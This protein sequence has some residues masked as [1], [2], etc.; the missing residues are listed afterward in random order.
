MKKKYILLLLVSFSFGYE[1]TWSTTRFEYWWNSKINKSLFREPVSFIPYKIKLGYYNYGGMK[2][3]DNFPNNSDTLLSSP[4]TSNNNKNFDFIN[5]QK[6]RKGIALE[7]DFLS[8]NFFKKFQ[9]IVDVTIGIGYKLRK[10]SSKLLIP[11]DENNLDENW[12]DDNR[13]FFFNPTVHNLNINTNFI[14]Q[15]SNIFYSYYNFSYG[16]IQA[17][18]FEDYN[19]E[20]SIL[21]EG[22]SRGHAI[23]FNFVS[24]SKTKTYDFH[25]GL[26]LRFDELIINEISDLSAHIE[27]VEIREIGVNLNIGIGYGGKNTIGNTAYSQMINGEYIEA[28][29][30]FTFFKNEYPNH[31]KHKL[32]NKMIDFCNNKIAYQM[33]FKGNEEYNKEKINEALSWYKKAI[34]KSDNNDQ[35]KSEIESRKF[36][37]AD[38]LLKNLNNYIDTHSFDQTLNYL[39]YI[40]SISNRAEYKA[41]SKKIDLLNKKADFLLEKKNYKSAY[42]IYF[43]NKIIFPDKAY[44]SDGKISIIITNLIND[45]NKFID[46]KNYILAYEN[47][48]YLNTIYNNSNSFIDS[49]IK[50][51]KDR[52]DKRRDDRIGEVSINIVNDL[53]EKFSPQNTTNKLIIGDSYSKVVRLL[54]ESKDIKKRQFLDQEYLMIVYSI[55]NSYYQLYFK[56]NILFELEE[57]K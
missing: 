47:M 5:D 26:E 35:L 56:D 41:T 43:D 20:S 14:F 31:S 23:G 10:P 19:G 44:I 21:G 52:L 30:N 48:I 28:I 51:L 32:A 34:I 2:Y 15:I 37:I 8:Y 49:N 12:F 13:N 3:W 42:Q 17:Y 40:I 46:G 11:Y 50:I 4:I 1:N 38:K 27:K 9:N 29:E 22:Y 25:Y 57:I 6:H 7:I 36:L 53:K 18:L 33:F 55:N 45:I 39:D 54:G 24:P 16:T